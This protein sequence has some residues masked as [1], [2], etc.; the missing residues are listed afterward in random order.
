[1]RE[2]VRNYDFRH[3][4]KYEHPISMNVHLHTYGTVRIRVLYTQVACV[5]EQ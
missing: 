2:D 4:L 3:P 1:M 5:H